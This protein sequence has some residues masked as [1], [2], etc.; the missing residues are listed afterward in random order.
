MRSRRRHPLTV[1][2]ATL[3]LVAGLVGALGAAPADAAARPGRVTKVH[4]VERAFN[5]ITIKFAVP[6]AYYHQGAAVIVRVTKG[7]QAAA[8]PAKGM[9]VRTSADHEAT[10]TAGLKQD[11]PYT[12]ALW[13][14]DRGR[15]SHR[16]VFHARTA[17][18]HEPP[19]DIGNV[20]D[21]TS[22]DPT[23]QVRLTW[24]VGAGDE[25]ASIRIVRNTEPTTTGGTVFTLPGSARSF[26]DTTPPAPVTTEPSEGSP[27]SLYYWL[28]AKNTAGV[29]SR[30]YTRH[31]VMFGSSST[32]Q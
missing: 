15:L 27:S 11:T 2:V 12:F 29:Y 19:A 5:T 18:Y 8:R 16:V 4:V 32:S 22:L 7:R 14:R 23:P 30:L 31:Q 6:A 9:A 13:V 26:T 21:E 3:A 1:R 10:P 28:I 20:A 17:A 24:V 25:L